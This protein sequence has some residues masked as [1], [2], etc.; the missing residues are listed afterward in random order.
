MLYF[1]RWK[2]IAILLT[3]AVVCSF[4]IP[5]FFPEVGHQDLAGLGAAAAG[6]RP[7]PAGRLA[8]PA[9]GRPQRRAQA[10][11]RQ[12]ARRRAP[13]AA[14]FPHHLD[15][16]ADR[17]RQQRR[18][19]AA[20]RQRV[21]ERAHEAARAVAAA[22]RRPPGQR[23]AHPRGHRCRRRPDPADPDRCRDERAHPPDHR[24]VDPDRREAHQRARPRRADHPAP[25]RRPHPGAGAGPRRS[26][27]PDRPP[28]PD[29][30][31]RVPHGRQFG[32][33]AGGA[34]GPRA[35]GFRSAL[36][37]PGRPAGSDPRLQAG[38]GRRRRPDRRPGELRPAHQRADRV[39]PL[40]HQRRPQVRAGD[41][42]ERRPA[43]RDRARQQGDLGAGH[44]RADPRRL[45]ADL[46]QLHGGVREQ[47]RDPA[48]RRR[49]AGEAH[50]DRAARGR[51]RPRRGL[52]QGRRARL[53]RRRDPRHR[54]HARDLRPVRPVRQRRGRG[55]RRHDHRHPVVPERDADAAR[56]RRHRAHGR[57][58]GR[59]ERADLRAHPRGGA[60][61]PHADQCDRRRLHP[62]ARHHPRLQHHDLHRRR[63]AVLHR[64][65]TGAR[66][67]G[68]AR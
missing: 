18:G 31:A 66:L 36:R 46:R 44:P 58:R 30:Q 11:P 17:A 9:R 14:R 7:R 13:H 5:N 35:A 3:A 19:A 8:D 64:H 20:R 47:P 51:S 28:R 45:G 37:D 56:H 48:A 4:A 49:A 57:H 61:R 26:A 68:D 33:P 34:A 43:V 52:D 32:E 50:R 40:Q 62:R 21:P 41:P 55:Q 60:Q 10:A 27:T 54:V 24:A 67:R 38:A 16:P 22:R 63:R 6:A 12:P 42:G 15:D 59:L 2:V 23:P 53:D 25:G 65:R 29:R 39:V 1:S